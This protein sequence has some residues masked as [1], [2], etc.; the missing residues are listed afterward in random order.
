MSWTLGL[1]AWVGLVLGF[2]LGCWWGGHVADRW[3]DAQQA[4]WNR[5]HQKAG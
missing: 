1:A 5:E 2:V 3:L 4:T